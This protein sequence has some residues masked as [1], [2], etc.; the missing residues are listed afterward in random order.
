MSQPRTLDYA[1]A[2]PPDPIS[3]GR[4]LAAE[5]VGTFALVFAG[6]ASFILNA[7]HVGVALTFGLV[8]GVM[9]YAVGAVSGAHFNPA[10]SFG[11]A[12]ARRMKPRDAFAYASTQSV[13]GLVAAALLWIA[14][15]GAPAYGPT[16]P[17]LQLEFAFFTP[18]SSSNLPE[19]SSIRIYPYPNGLGLNQ[20][21]EVVGI[22]RAI[23]FEILLTFFLVFVILCVAIGS[24]ER[25]LM[26]GI[27]IGG[28][29]AFCALAGGP[30]SGASMNPARSLGPALVTGGDAIRYLW[31]YWTAPFLGSVTAV[32]A[33]TYIYRH[34]RPAVE[35]HPVTEAQP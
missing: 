23:G 8:V 3:L 24:K 34:S 15:P 7:G 28:T 10:V 12:L 1:S 18:L 33:W 17:A 13:A 27:A 16:T 35:V 11:F 6:C 29:I 30:V 32:G 21:S 25:G 31:I 26:A 19:A 22:I 20:S 14:F 4:R 9:I 5:F 2:P